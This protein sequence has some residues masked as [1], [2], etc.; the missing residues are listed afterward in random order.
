[1]RLLVF[2]VDDIAATKELLVENAVEHDLK[3]Q[4]LV[5]PPAPGQGATFIFE[6]LK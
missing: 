3:G 1:M 6:D 4:R 2:A 5:V